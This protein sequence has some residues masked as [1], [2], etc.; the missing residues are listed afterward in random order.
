MSHRHVQGRLLL[1]ACMALA[2]AAAAVG[3]AAADQVQLT[4]TLSGANEV[5][6]PGDPH[7]TGT[8][9]ISV[10]TQTAQL[11]FQLTVSGLS[12]PATAAHIHHGTPDVAGPV[13]VPLAPPT[14][15]TSSGCVAVDP[16]LA[17]GIATYSGAYYANV[18]TV[19]FP[20][21]AARGQ[22]GQTSAGGDHPAPH[23]APAAD[24]Q[25]DT[26]TQVHQADEHFQD[27]SDGH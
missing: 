3:P 11:C 14:D 9:L 15:G 20:N 22:L 27:A 26:S 8:A 23:E 19:D 21:G 25:A 4:A 7:A 1:A 2:G 12:S 16:N 10:D 18:H 6:G 24:H 13:V 5:P 17:A